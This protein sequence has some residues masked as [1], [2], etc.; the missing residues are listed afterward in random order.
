MLLWGPDFQKP[1]AYRKILCIVFV[2]TINIDMRSSFSTKA[3]SSEQ[4]LLKIYFK[5]SKIKL[6]RS[7]SGVKKKM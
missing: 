6:G 3:I 1:S 2:S 7:K 5:D 4:V